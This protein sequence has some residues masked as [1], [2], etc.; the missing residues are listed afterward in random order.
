MYPARASACCSSARSATPSPPATTSTGWYGA[1]RCCTA[2]A[3]AATVPSPEAQA[4]VVSA[5]LADAGVSPR[6]IGYLE[7]HA[8][9]T[10]LGDQI[11]VEALTSVY[12][13]ASDDRGYCA[14]GSAKPVIGHLEA[15]AGI[16]GITKVLMALRHQTLPAAAD[17]GDP[18]P[19]IHWE[20]TPFRLPA[21]AEPWAPP[22]DPADGSPLP[23]RAAVSAFGAGGANAHVIVEEFTAPDVPRPAGGRPLAVPV[24]ARSASALREQAGRLAA[25]LSSGPDL[26]LADVAHTLRAGRRAMAHRLAVVAS[27]TAELADGLRAFAEGRPPVWPVH[28]GTVADGSDAG[29]ARRGDEDD[30]ARRWVT[31]SRIE[32]SVPEGAR[33]VSLPTYPFERSRHWLGD[34][35][36]PGTA[37]VEVPPAAS[38]G[39]PRRPHA[40]VRAVHHAPSAAGPRCRSGR[41]PARVRHRSGPDARAARAAPRGRHRQAGHVVPAHRARHVRDRAG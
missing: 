2:G 18:H 16:A 21:R 30:T 26:E 17:V 31:G 8:S 9:G 29:P 35:A 19:S 4:R 33:R 5:A 28:T 12:S 13:A 39:T 37:A 10:P 23:R 41:P 24:S 22:V 32:W 38:A 6:T 11:E 25:H 14:I 15:A 1:R 20:T 3:P 36:Q 7:A 34:T 40:A 27:T